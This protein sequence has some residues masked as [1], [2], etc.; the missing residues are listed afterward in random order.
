MQERLVEGAFL[1]S[2]AKEQFQLEATRTEEMKASK[3]ERSVT[4]GPSHLLV[5][6]QMAMF[7]ISEPY[8]IYFSLY[9]PQMG[10]VT[11]EFLVSQTELGLPEDTSLMQRLYT[12]FANV[13]TD[14]VL[15]QGYIVM[16]IYRKGCLQ[17]TD[18]AMSLSTSYQRPFACGVF[19]LKSVSDSLLLGVQK[20]LEECQIY[21]P[22]Q[23]ASFSQVHELLIQKRFAE[24]EEIPM[25]RG[26]KLCLC[27]VQ[28]E[29]ANF[30]DLSF[31]EKEY[32]DGKLRDNLR[33]APITMP[34]R[35]EEMVLDESMVR[36]AV[37]CQL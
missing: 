12:L 25:S 27:L 6:M 36:E 19:E 26:I 30:K 20:E 2:S 31:L 14:D 16:K 23:E 35:Y 37:R 34:V 15:E 17:E 11:E 5:E 4:S 21:R 18:K 3:A 22:K 28:G 29:I 8:S 24:L 7:K 32:S 13:N 9:I 10:F 1:P 33:D